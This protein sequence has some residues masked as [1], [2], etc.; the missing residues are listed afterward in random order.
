[1]IGWLAGWLAVGGLTDLLWLVG[2]LWLDGQLAGWL[3]GLWAS[4]RLSVQ[5]S[6]FGRA[7][8]R[9]SVFGVRAF[10]FGCCV[11]AS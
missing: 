2:W 9:R 3:A 8:V 6:V 10:V 11:R 4:G 5:F 1:M 7:L